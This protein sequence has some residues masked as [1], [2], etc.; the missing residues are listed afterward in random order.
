MILEVN[1][2]DNRGRVPKSLPEHRKIVTFRPKPNYSLDTDPLRIA[3]P[4]TV[5]DAQRMA[6]ALAPSKQEALIPAARRQLIP[7]E[8][9][10]AA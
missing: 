5:R 10:D 2:G 7:D 8:G 9:R 6:L 4:K 3:P 1:P